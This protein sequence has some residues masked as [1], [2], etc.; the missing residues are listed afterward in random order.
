MPAARPDPSP[1][2]PR[3]P[4]G[5]G[6]LLRGG[7]G[8][9]APG[10]P[11]LLPAAGAPTTVAA[12]RTGTQ[13]GYFHSFWTDSPGTCA[14]TLGPGGEYSVA[15]ESTGN[16]VCGKG[17]A[18]GGRRTVEWSGEFA[19]S[20]N[21]YVCVYGWTANPLVEY[22]IVDDWGAFRPTGVHKGA[23][24]SDGG[25]YDVYETVRYNAPSV[26]G[27]TTFAQ[28]WS[29]RRAKRTGG[30]ITTGAHFDAWTGRGMRL[31]SFDH[32]MILATEGYQ[33]SGRADI[34]MG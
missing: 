2:R 12:N 3:N 32:Y 26:E 4:F 20:G 27:T 24:S 17:W 30:A 1:A 7:A 11:A 33:G 23:V 16:F 14:M 10:G 31:G 19:P 9:L 34:R 8:P 21:G 29:V 22:F 28:F 25:T 15:W 5:R 6:G 13:G 18:R